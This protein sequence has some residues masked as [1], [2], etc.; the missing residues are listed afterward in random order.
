[1]PKR[2]NSFAVENFDELTR[3]YTLGTLINEKLSYKIYTSL[4]NFFIYND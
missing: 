1:M 2:C 4:T 3:D